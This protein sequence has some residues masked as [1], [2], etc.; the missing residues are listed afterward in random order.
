MEG[1]V[2][3]AEGREAEVFLRADGSVL[4]LL[5]EP[6]WVFRADR[7][8]AA[9]AVLR[10]QGYP[11]PELLGRLTDDDGRP[12]LLLS[13]IDG[14]SLL[15]VLGRRPLAV[16]AAGRTMGLAHAA[17]HGCVAPA[18]LPD[19]RDL[20]RERI[21]RAEPLPASHRAAVLAL[22]DDLPGGDRLC[23]GD[24][25]LGNILGS[26]KRP[27]VIDWGDASRGDPTADVARTV[28]LHRVG[29]LPP[30]S[31][32]LLRYLAPVGRGII[33]A[34]YQATYRRRRPVDAA[35]M[36]RWETVWAAARLAEPVP[37]EY[38]TL[39]RLLADRL[40]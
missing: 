26:W 8:A 20:L 14:D 3:L 19:L 15:A 10:A 38:P 13:R 30:G 33:V 29:V 24:M 35:A 21:D 31:A 32:T 28:L 5:R 34:R 39:L 12:G 27:V 11:A 16:F 40:G 36:T 9:L 4:K 17:M 22:L 37:E 1:R 2:L 25:H 23:H 7:E 18:E 6:D